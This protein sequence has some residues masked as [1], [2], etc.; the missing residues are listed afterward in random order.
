MKRGGAHSVNHSGR[1]SM[2]KT[3]I[4]GAALI[5]ALLLVF[6]GAAAEAASL[7]Y[8]GSLN[9][10]GRAAEGHYDL[11]LT[12]FG[13][14]KGGEPLAPPLSVSNVEMR[15]GHFN[16]EVNFDDGVP[17]T[18][19][20]G[21]AVRRSGETD[22]VNLAERSTLHPAG[23]CDNAWLL[24][25]NAGTANH[26]FFLG[27]TDETPLTIAVDSRNSITSFPFSIGN[28]FEANGAQARA[29]R[30]TAINYSQ[31]YAT[32]SF[33]GGY[34]ANTSAGH[35][36]SFVWGGTN[37]PD[38][39]NSTGPN[40]FDV[41]ADGGFFINTSVPSSINDDLIIYPRPAPGDADVDLRFIT[42][43]GINQ[44]LIYVSNA[45]G[46]MYLGASAGVHIN[47]PV[48][49][50]GELKSAALHVEGDA[51][52]TTA[53]AWKANSDRRIKQDIEPVEKALDT[54]AKLRPVSFRYTDGYRGA[55]D[56]I[57]DRRYYNVIA[58]EFAE[59][60]PEAVTGSGEYIDSAAKTPENEIL[61]VDTYPAQIVT[62]AAVQE[63]AQKNA[64][65]Q[66]T[67]NQLVTRLAKL[68]ALREK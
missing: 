47:N 20:V 6:D 36:H 22:F 34:L 5:A 3:P 54:L 44:G 32:D 37:Q 52:K 10:G 42:R 45:S 4:R 2:M 68:E 60:F 8:Q 17:S 1:E 13:S 50:E 51:S 62:I 31:A 39:A 16:T 58:Q 29:P 63:L 40:Q 59:V 21:V 28:S 41:W 49:V 12:L 9:D 27:T 23:T 43:D 55:H 67:V 18:A 57:A 53:G 33:A 7:T 35:D 26:G 11:Q 65:L 66:A 38:I 24:T 14:E 56:G 19:W 48:A 61:Q 25:G 64:A 46:V 30:A 15:S